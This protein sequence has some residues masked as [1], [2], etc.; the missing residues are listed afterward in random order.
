MTFESVAI[1]I[2]RALVAE[3][4]FGTISTVDQLAGVFRP[5]VRVVHPDQNGN[6]E[7]ADRVFRRLT[8]L[9]DHAELKLKNGT[10]GDRKVPNTPPPPPAHTPTVI[11][12]RAHH[13]V[14]ERLLFA[15]DV[16]DIYRATC[17]VKPGG[18]GSSFKAA[19]KIAR[20]SADNDL[21]EAELRAY[22]K[23]EL[24]KSDKAAA[25]L[26]P[27]L[28]DSFLF[29]SPS[30]A[31]RR[32]N[33]LS[34]HYDHYSLA[35]V[36]AVHPG[37]DYRD[38]V[39][40]FKRSLMALGFTH[41]RGL[42]HGAVLPPHIL[43]DPIGHGIE[44]VDWCYSVEKEGQIRVISKA[45]KSFYPKEVITKKPAVPATDIFMLAKTMVRLL[46]GD[47]E[48]NRMPD[49]VPHPITSFLQSCLLPAPGR[50]PDDAWKL[51]EELD[52]L[53]LRLVG[54]PK[55]RKLAMPAREVLDGR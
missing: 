17:D 24:D 18:K 44:L 22:E 34:S 9:R 47:V 53:L 40:M 29:R 54:K 41:R 55:Y 35:E 10:Y 42:V 8:E 38:A 4:L 46:G 31:T 30:G 50:R 13:Y 21:L 3:D 36:R 52:E 45:H 20:S 32:V 28:L 25:K 26:F 12:T 15:G 23:L 7:R 19:F 48:T 51:H 33:V 6:S 16:A 1:Q 14:V 49:S 27:R 11:E 5:M 39:W 2:E 43:V 37:L